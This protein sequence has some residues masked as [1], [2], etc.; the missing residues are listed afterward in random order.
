MTQKT[1]IA[2]ARKAID[3]YNEEPPASDLPET[4]SYPVKLLVRFSIFT[5]SLTEHSSII[6]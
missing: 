2:A 6:S 3:N 4:P 5:S 1:D